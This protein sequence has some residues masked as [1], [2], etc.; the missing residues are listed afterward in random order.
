MYASYENYNTAPEK[1]REQSQRPPEKEM[2]RV[3]YDL[4]DAE[5]LQKA[6]GVYE[7]IVVYAWAEWCNPCKAIAP[8]FEMLGHK[9]IKYL[10][11]NQ[12]LLLK[13]NIETETSIHREHVNV[14]P[15][16]FVY[17]RGEVVEIFTGV[18][19]DKLEGFLS[20]YFQE[21]MN[22]TRIFK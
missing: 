12:L 7:V 2:E 8:K 6:K 14:I 9:M 15:T 21:K 16:F 10:Q 1:K 4:V 5:P 19:F 18:D 22:N 13:D 20:N 11:S 17:V 3:S